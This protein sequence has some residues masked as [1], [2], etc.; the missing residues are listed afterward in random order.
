MDR[1][2]LEQL[3]EAA[4][5]LEAI[6]AEWNILEY[7]DKAFAMFYDARLKVRYLLQQEKQG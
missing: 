7:S 2:N 3:Q 5:S 4:K 6:L 1:K